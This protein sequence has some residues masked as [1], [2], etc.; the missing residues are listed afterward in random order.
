MNGARRIAAL[1][2]FCLILHFQG[3]GM[4][5][6]GIPEEVTVEQILDSLYK[7]SAAVTD[8]SGWAKVKARYGGHEQ[9]ATTVI[10]FIAPDRIKVDL[11]GFAGIELASISTDSDSM[12]VY[13]P[14]LNG[15]VKGENRE[16]LLNKLVP[17]FEFDVT[18]I[19]SVFSIQAPLRDTITKFQ[20]SLKRKGNRMEMTLIRGDMVYR[21]LVEGPQLVVVEED[22][23]VGGTSVWHKRSE[24]FRS[25]GAGIFPRKMTIRNDRGSL[26][27]VFYS[28]SI[29]S[30]LS[31]KDTAIDMPDS[32]ERLRLKNTED[33]SRKTE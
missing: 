32:A 9:S 30:G 20:T 17:D 5:P 12:T 18:R 21:Y 7:Q 29:N 25:A 10:R 24:D 1:A 11:K 15:Y 4:K 13:L 3:C 33:R 19:A 27:F 26:D 6:P 16:G 23:V 31:M 2:L 28:V 22:L 8:F 14:S